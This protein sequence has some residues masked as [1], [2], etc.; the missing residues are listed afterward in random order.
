MET[1][2]KFSHLYQVV[3]LLLLGWSCFFQY[4]DLCVSHF[5]DSEV[6]DL[7]FITEGARDPERL[8]VCF[9]L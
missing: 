4:G 9:L 1:L 8:Q 6:R 3:L 7:P 2:R 5:T